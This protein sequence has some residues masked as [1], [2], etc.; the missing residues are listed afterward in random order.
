MTKLVLSYDTPFHEFE[1]IL[2]EH[3]QLCIIPP[4]VV[5]PPNSAETTNPSSSDPDLAAPASEPATYT[6]Y[7]TTWVKASLPLTR[8]EKGY[9]VKDGPW[10]C[11]ITT[12]KGVK[13]EEVYLISD[14]TSYLNLRL[15][16][17]VKNRKDPKNECS[18]MI[19][20]VS[21]SK[22]RPQ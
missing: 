10:H 14:E 21:Q 5:Q 16:I 11:R 22:S 9:T 6:A 3:T 15:R 20:H 1:R 4:N 17:E 2:Q 7:G 8:A 12:T 19:M 18:V 13:Q